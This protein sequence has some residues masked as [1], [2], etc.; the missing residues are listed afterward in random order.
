MKKKQRQL[1][2]DALDSALKPPTTRRAPSDNLNSLLSQYAPRPVPEGIPSRGILAEGIPREGIPLSGTPRQ[3]IPRQRTPKK[4]AALAVEVRAERGYYPTFNDLDDRVI[5]QL[6]VYE[7]SILRRLYRL[8]RGF[9]SQECE[10]GLGALARATNM[11]RSKAQKAVA[12]LLARGILNSLGNS[13][14]GTK[15]RV[16]A[17]FPAVPQKGI[18]PQGIPQS[19]EGIP[20]EGAQG[21]P[22]QGHIKYNQEDKNSKK[23]SELSLDIKLCPDCQGSGFYYPEGIEKGVAKCKHEKLVKEGKL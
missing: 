20:Q 17:Q 13:Q 4:E 3:G 11:S 8:S 18:P 14:A 10:A 23:G 16:L 1:I 12:S 22:Q 9:K 19:G 2:D 6:D 7:Q 5:P 15:Y 21:I